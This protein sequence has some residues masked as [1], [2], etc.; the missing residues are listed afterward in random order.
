MKPESF[1][2]F[3]YLKAE[4]NEDNGIYAIVYESSHS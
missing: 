3:V 2:S 1:L 4:L